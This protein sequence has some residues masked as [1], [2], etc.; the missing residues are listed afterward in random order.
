MQQRVTLV[1]L[2]ILVW[3]FLEW[4]LFRWRVDF[5]L[6][7]LKCS[8]TINGSSSNTG[9]M[10]VNRPFEVTL[11]ISPVRS[12]RIPMVRIEEILPE[13]VL[14]IGSA[15]VGDFA[16]SGKT[17]LV[18]NYT[19]QPKA[20]GDLK[21]PG[22]SLRVFDLQ[23]LFYAQRFIQHPQTF[24][25]LPT[26]AELDDHLPTLKR[27]NSVPPPGIHRL[28]QAGMGSELLELREY[29][30]GDPPKSIAWKVSA[31]RDQLMTRQYE[32]EVP[33]RTI[34]FVDA[35]IST[36][37]GDFGQRTLDQMLFVA[38]SVAKSAMSAR[39]PVGLIRFD[40][41]GPITIRP[42]IG[43]RHFYRLLNELTKAA[44]VNSPP[45]SRLNSQLVELAWSV[46]EER[47]PQLL[48]KRTN[49]IPFSLFPLFPSSRMQWHKR[50][51]LV[52]ALSEQYTQKFDQFEKQHKS[53][54]NREQ[55]L[56]SSQELLYDDLKFASLLQRFLIDEGF[57]WREPVVE[58][59][60]LELHHWDRKFE[61][62]TNSLSRS[63][64]GARDNELYVLLVDLID[65]GGNLGSL[66][67]AIRLARARHHR[68]CV[69][70]PVPEFLSD[71]DLETT[72]AHPLTSDELLLRAE[73]LRI[74]RAQDNLKRELIRLGASVSFVC[75]RRAIKQVLSEV[76]LLRS[77]RT[78]R[79]NANTNA[80][81]ISS[82]IT[83]RSR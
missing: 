63:V 79:G 74:R 31:R 83:G 42:S 78:A 37:S 65:C 9:M 41:T 43:E 34:L 64:S 76:N 73:V 26:F 66:A 10:R 21:L 19:A 70:S 51:R 38:A 14:A 11:V 69:L 52:N 1:S 62:L 33:V 77:G 50:I 6:P 60:S 80:A 53:P 4:L 54:V 20:A 3:L 36:R 7:Y 49:L 29:V 12:I 23:G 30:P 40:N 18:I 55:L 47:Y 16:I 81:K 57:A 68:V 72:H 24:R 58:R 48:N 56:V 71:V 67:D 8:R 27:L 15:P 22:V 32:S 25:V 82:A 44:T 28:H 5:E 46:C 45:R 39:D 35:S 59:R 61:L 75:D 13:N 2:G 17:P